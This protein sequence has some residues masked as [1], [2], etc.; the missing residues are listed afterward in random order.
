MNK[1]ERPYY[2]V[3]PTIY[4]S[5]TVT[6]NDVSVI[7]WYGEQTKEGGYGGGIPINHVLLQ[8]GKYKITGKMYPRIG[9]KTLTEEEVLY[10]DFYCA[11]G[12][13]G[14]TK[15]TR[16]SIHPK[17][18]S[19]WDGLSENINY[20]YYEITTEIEVELPFI[21]DGWQNSVDLS[22]INETELF[23]KT[24]S[25][26]RQV[27]ALL[28]EHNAVKFLE[29]SQEKMKLQETA[30]YFD[31]ARKM[32]FREGALALFNENLEVEPLIESEL[33][34]EI[35]GYG[36]L[37]RLMKLDGSQP[38]QFK[39]PNIKEQSNVELEVKLHMRNVDKGFSII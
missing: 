5:G 37:V 38:L 15:E 26:Y 23:N 36:K 22:K 11:N 3:D 31:E 18:E 29:I 2:T 20:P 17:I 4:C 27:H 7:D 8:S 35:M 28:K 21:L 32:S 30:F 6:V 10:I 25:Y 1:F 24:L 16:I 19:P 9:K 12:I 34:L 14:K 33:K 13:V 39:S